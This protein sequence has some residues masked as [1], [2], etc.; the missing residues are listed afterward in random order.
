[1]C[2]ELF[3]LLFLSAW[4]FFVSIKY[5]LCVIP[6]AEL[7]LKLALVKLED[8]SDYFQSE[9]IVANEYIVK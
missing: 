6:E 7:G 4:Y 9:Y 1:M 5:L 2:N 8:L 3:L